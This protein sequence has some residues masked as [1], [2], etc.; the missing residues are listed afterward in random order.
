MGH[1]QGPTRHWKHTL[2]LASFQ[3]LYQGVSAIDKEWGTGLVGEVGFRTA[4][5]S[6]DAAKI[7]GQ[8]A[9]YG[10]APYQE[11]GP[12]SSQLA[13]HRGRDAVVYGPGPP[14]SSIQVHSGLTSSERGSPRL[15]AMLHRIWFLGLSRWLRVEPLYYGDDRGAIRSYSKGAVLCMWTLWEHGMSG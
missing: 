5:V 7:L 2:V 10:M 14:L 15:E 1:L 11:A 4:D 6:S 3:D 9:T 8:N 13:V 12:R